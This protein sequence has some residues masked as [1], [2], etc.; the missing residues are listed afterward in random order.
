METSF[1]TNLLW[2]GIGI[3]VVGSFYLI[4]EGLRV[5]KLFAESIIGKLVKTLVIVVLIELY[6]L[7]VVSF[8]FLNLFPKGV[9][10]LLPIVGLW[11]L[12]LV[13]AIYAIH[14]TRSEV[15]KLTK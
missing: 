12:C 3:L 8:A 6:S 10:V 11:I 7:G 2:I 1:L 5:H 9:F 13:Y 4:V 14:A 15:G